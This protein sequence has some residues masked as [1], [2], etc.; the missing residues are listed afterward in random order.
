MGK[1]VSR[2]R[3]Q[4][5]RRVLRHDAGAH[6]GVEK[7]FGQSPLHNS[8]RKSISA[9]SSARAFKI[10]D[11][12]SPLLIIG[13][14]INPTG[15]KALQQELL[16]GKMNI[17]RQMARDQ[18]KQGAD[19]LDV[20]VGVHGID[21]I[22]AIR[23]VIRLLST[24]TDLPLVIDSPN[25]ETI[26]AALRIY[27]GRALI[28]SISGE[29]KKLKKLLPLAAKYGAMFILLPLT[30]NEIPETAARRKIIIRYIPGREDMVFRKMTSS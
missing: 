17:V 24:G 20:N 9:V 13:E 30:D 28:N 26:E 8:M 14:R 7:G 1:A 2:C 27:P 6:C 5:Y 29:K 3:R 12:S 15:K 23:N 22:D 11:E 4:H 21:E 10:F 16:D 19:L 25:M 18:E